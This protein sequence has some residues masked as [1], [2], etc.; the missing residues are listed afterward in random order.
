MGRRLSLPVF[1][2]PVYVRELNRRIAHA[3]NKFLI[4]RYYLASL[5][6]PLIN[7]IYSKLVIHSIDNLKS[8]IIECL[9]YSWR[10]VVG[11]DFR[12]TLASRAVDKQHNGG[13]SKPERRYKDPPYR[14]S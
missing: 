5:F 8:P 10:A 1:R 2:H 9:K 14:P 11:Q 6:I 4:P 7:K 13:E 12:L 3:R